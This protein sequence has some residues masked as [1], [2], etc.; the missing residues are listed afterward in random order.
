MTELNV[1]ESDSKIE[2]LHPHGPK[3]TFSWP[4]VADKCFVP[5]SNICVIIVPA[6]ITGWMYQISDTDFEQT[7]KAYEK[8]K[9]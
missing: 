6:T 9:M 2:F 8:H 7:L 5:A 4:S 3:E 1:H